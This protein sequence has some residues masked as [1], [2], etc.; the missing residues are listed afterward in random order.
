MMELTQDSLKRL[1]E[2]DPMTGDL[3]HKERPR[4]MFKTGRKGGEVA[5]RIWNSRYAGKTVSSRSGSGYLRVSLG[6]KRYS[7]HRIIWVM[8]HGY[9]PNEIDHINGDRTDNRAVNLRE[10]SRRE[11]MKNCA[12]RSNSGTGVTGVSY[13]KRDRKYIAYIGAGNKTKVIGRY[14]CLTA[15]AVAR[16]AAEIEHGYHPN[17]GRAA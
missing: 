9:E 8:L 17:H 13:V 15:A 16:K 4:E 11:N 14:L 10:V 12:V 1:F 3:R 2:Y 7:C 5:W 6:G